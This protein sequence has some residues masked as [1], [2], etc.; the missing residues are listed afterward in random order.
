MNTA[1]FRWVHGND[2]SGAKDPGREVWM[3][4][5]SDS[6]KGIGDNGLPAMEG[7]LCRVNLL[8]E[9]SGTN[10]GSE[11]SEGRRGCEPGSA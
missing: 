6:R 1:H 2:F 9:V 8:F 3:A 11:N 5:P 10:S 4:H 7:L